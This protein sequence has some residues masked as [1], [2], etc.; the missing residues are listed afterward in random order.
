MR[1]NL[2]LLPIMVVFF[3]TLVFWWKFIYEF[4]NSKD[5]ITFAEWST[6]TT[7]VLGSDLFAN[8]QNWKKWSLK[9]FDPIY[10]LISSQVTKSVQ[11]TTKTYNYPKLITD[12]NWDWLPDLIITNISELSYEQLDASGNYRTRNYNK[13]DYVLLLNKGNLEYDIKYRCVYSDWWP[14]A[15]FYWDCAK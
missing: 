2:V 3:F 14:S 7:P 4:S 11:W 15:W 1:K 10:I 13:Y 12:V 6:A 5:Y 9:D 8:W